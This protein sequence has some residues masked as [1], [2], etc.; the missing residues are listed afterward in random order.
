MAAGINAWYKSSLIFL[1]FTPIALGTAFYLTPKVTGRPIH[2]YS[3]IHAAA[4][5]RHMEELKITV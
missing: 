5:L 3:L 4:L 2:S 1:F